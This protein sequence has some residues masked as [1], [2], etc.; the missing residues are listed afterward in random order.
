MMV[1]IA[2][3]QERTDW[4]AATARRLWT[5]GFIVDYQPQMATFRLF[6]PYIISVEEIDRFLA[7]FEQ[8]AREEESI[9][10]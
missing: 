3:Q 1:G 8:I 4:G 6:P 7:A 9:L 10:A 2:L 5:A